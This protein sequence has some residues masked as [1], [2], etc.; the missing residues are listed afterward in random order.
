MRQ[1][2]ELMHTRDGADNAASVFFSPDRRFFA[3]LGFPAELDCYYSVLSKLD[4]HLIHYI[5]DLCLSYVTAQRPP[6]FLRT[7][8]HSDLDLL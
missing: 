7:H 4:S 5:L 1:K 6:H 8:Y 2:Q 3:H